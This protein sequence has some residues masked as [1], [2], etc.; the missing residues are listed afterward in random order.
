MRLYQKGS[1]NLP[2]NDDPLDLDIEISYAGLWH[3]LNDHVNY[4]AG[5]EGFGVVEQT[6]RRKDIVSDWFKGSYSTGQVQDNTKRTMQVYVRGQTMAD[7]AESREQLLLWFTQDEYSL[8]I[9]LDDLLETMTC[10]CA[11]Y[12]IDMNHVFLHNRMCA[13]TL[14]Y[15]VRPTTSYEMVF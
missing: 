8:R 5:V 3:S 1:V 2:Y 13:V 14:M 11:D 15:S 6:W 4:R 12:R 7:M 9:R 10:E